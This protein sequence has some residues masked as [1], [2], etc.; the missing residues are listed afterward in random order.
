MWDDIVSNVIDMWNDIV[1]NVIDMWDDSVQHILSHERNTV[2]ARIYE[3][4]VVCVY[5]CCCFVIMYA[6]EKLFRHS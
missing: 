2:E 3:A 4:L 1:A 5:I 6:V